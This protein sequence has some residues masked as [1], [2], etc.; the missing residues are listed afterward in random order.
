MANDSRS[1]TRSPERVNTTVHSVPL[2]DVYLYGNNGTT[3]LINGT[4]YA[5][6]RHRGAPTPTICGGLDVPTDSDDT[7]PDDVQHYADT[8]TSDD[9]LD[10]PEGVMGLRHVDLCRRCRA[11]YGTGGVP[12]DVGVVIYKMDGSGWER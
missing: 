6:A 7:L 1:E 11:S 4:E 10:S 9:I 12:A 3:H 5:R 2:P 8:L